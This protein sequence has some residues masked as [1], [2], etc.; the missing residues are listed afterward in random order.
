MCSG[1]LFLFVTGLDNITFSLK[2]WLKLRLD[3]AYLAISDK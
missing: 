3:E 2:E 1:R